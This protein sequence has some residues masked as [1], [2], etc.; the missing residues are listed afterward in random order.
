[1]GTSTTYLTCKITTK[2]PH[3]ITGAMYYKDTMNLAKVVD[4]IAVDLVVNDVTIKVKTSQCGYSKCTLALTYSLHHIPVSYI[5][6]LLINT[7]IIQAAN[8]L[9][10]GKG[11][12]TQPDP[13]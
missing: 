5:E 6:E 2:K 3:I 12:E 7:V 4:M 10:K 11:K 13:T 1:M 8:D 9:S